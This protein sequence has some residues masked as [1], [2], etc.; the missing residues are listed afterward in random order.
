MNKCPDELLGNVLRSIAKKM[1]DSQL[2]IFV[3][4]CDE[5]YAKYSKH[6]KKELE[7]EIK[8]AE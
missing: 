8:S 3:K 6:T 5:S 7:K 1:P 2:S 4:F